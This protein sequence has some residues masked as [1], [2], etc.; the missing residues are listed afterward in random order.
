MSESNVTGQVLG[1]VTTISG[2]TAVSA[3]TGHHSVAMYCII[4]AAG[5]GVLVLVG[6]IIGKA[7]VYALAR[8]Y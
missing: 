2:A 6:K 1:S 5:C 3:V 7:I 4:V 8:P